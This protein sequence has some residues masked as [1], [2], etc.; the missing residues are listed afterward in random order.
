MSFIELIFNVPQSLRALF[1]KLENIE[2]KL[3]STNWSITF[4]KVCLKEN[5]LPTYTTIRH[6]DPAVRNTS[7]TLDYRRY[8]IKREIEL[9]EKDRIKICNQRDLIVKQIEEYQ[10]D[11]HMKADIKNALQ[12][13]L[14]NSEKVQKIRSLKKLNTL[15]NG[16]VL[17]KEN[18]DCFVNLSDH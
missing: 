10:G 11:E 5:I 6:H 12:S 4:N 18:V 14:R 2:K 13:I 16:Q 17:I 9:K 3:I 15:Y 7:N 8:L 1:R